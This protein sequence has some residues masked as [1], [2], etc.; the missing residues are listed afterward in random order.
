M[1]VVEEV[2]G[3]EDEQQ[4]QQKHHYCY[5]LVGLRLLHHPA[6]VGQGIV[7]RTFLKQLR[8]DFVVVFVQRQVVQSQSCYGRLVA[9]IEYH[10]EIHAHTVVKPFYFG[11]CKCGIA[12]LVQQ[13]ATVGMSGKVLQIE[14]FQTRIGKQNSPA[15]CAG[16]V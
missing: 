2:V 7:G 4:H 12:A 8:I 3:W 10:A 14:V 11:R 13:Y 16:D 15:V 9:N 1:A 5:G 6:V